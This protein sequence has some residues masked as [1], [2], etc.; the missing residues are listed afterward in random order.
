MERDYQELLD[1]L[2]EGTLN[3]L[4]I[5]TEEFM[6]FQKILMDYQQRKSIVGTAKRGGGVI[7]HFNSGNTGTL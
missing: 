7:Y 1:Q 6:D 2:R 4:E 3:E 5:S